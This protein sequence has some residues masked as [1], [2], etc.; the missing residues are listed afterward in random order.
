MG[1]SAGAS[2]GSIYLSTLA[3]RYTR[4]LWIGFAITAVGLAAI[5]FNVSMILQKTVYTEWWS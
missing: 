5:V 4:S 3:P 1:N 2:I